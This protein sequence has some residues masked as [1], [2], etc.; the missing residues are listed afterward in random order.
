MIGGAVARLVVVVLLAIYAWR[1]SSTAKA[2][3]L[4]LEWGTAVL[5]IVFAAVVVLRPGGGRAVGV[6]ICLAISIVYGGAAV[7]ISKGL[8]PIEG[9]ASLPQ[10]RSGSDK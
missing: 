2:L 9:E 8:G 6:I 5:G 10:S 3:L 7:A 1:G 4:V